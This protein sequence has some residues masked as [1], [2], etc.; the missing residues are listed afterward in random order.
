MAAAQ[1]GNLPKIRRRNLEL[2]KEVIHKYGPVSRSE[3]A[4]ILALTPP[5]I[6]TTVSKLMKQGLVM[7]QDY[8]EPETEEKALGR[9]R[10]QLS[11]NPDARLYLGVELGPYH[12]TMC[13]IDLCGRVLVSR[14]TAAPAHDY[15]EMLLRLTDE[16]QSFL[17]DESIAPRKC[18]GIAV[19]LP[20]F[21]SKS[22]GRIRN[23]VRNDWSNRYLAD[24]LQT[25]L[26][27]P[28]CIENNVRARAIG[29]ELYRA[30]QL[31]DVDMLA[32]FFISMGIACPITIKSTVVSG[33]TA[34]A[35][36]VGHMVV[37]INGPICKTCGNRGCLEAVAGEKAILDTCRT[38]LHS[39]RAVI[40][41]QLCPDPDSLNMKDVLKALEL[42]DT[43]VQEVLETAVTYLGVTL[44]NI[45]NFI[46]PQLVIVDGFMFQ[47]RQLCEQLRRVA[48]KNLFGLNGKEVDIVFAEHDRFGGAKGA[49]AMAIREFF[50]KSESKGEAQ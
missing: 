5:T 23:S 22:E 28:I 47:S 12:T 31:R 36:E 35:G 42:G 44:A 41:A 15:G 19:G 46:S 25:M 27:I 43:G 38:M 18:D 30:E 48:S 37:D 45:I 17:K 10:V 9:R 21:I 3:I 20:G 24:D 4:E 16:I 13:A 14:D 2:I 8:A 1:G 40:L 6:T 39:N 34:G 33:Y 7:E 32:Y 29:A 26:G 50:I 49:A 11:L